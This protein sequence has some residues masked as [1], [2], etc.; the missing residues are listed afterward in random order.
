MVFVLSVL[1][2]VQCIMIFGESVL[3]RLYIISF[4]YVLIINRVLPV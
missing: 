4:E 2:S 1:N 3:N